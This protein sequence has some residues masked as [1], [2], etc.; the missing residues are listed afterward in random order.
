VKESAA[1]NNIIVGIKIIVVLLFIALGVFH[2][3]PANWTHLCP[4]DGRE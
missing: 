1:L 2:I 3:K 4:L